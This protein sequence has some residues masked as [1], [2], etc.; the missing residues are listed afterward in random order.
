MRSQIPTLAALAVLAAMSATDVRAGEDFTID[1]QGVARHYLMHRPAS[2]APERPLVIF[3]HELRPAAWQ[4]H[5]QPD[6]DAL[7]DRE[8][9][10]VIYPEALEHRWNYTGQLSAPVKAD[11]QIADDV[12]FIRNLIDDL[13][14]RRLVDPRLVYAIGDSRGGLVTFELM[15]HLADR[16]AAAAP[17]ITGMTEG[18]RAACKPVRA[19]PIFA[20]DG[21]DDPVQPYDGWLFPTGRLLSVPETMEFW[22][23]QHSC[24]GQ[25]ATL[26][27]H[28]IEADPTKL[29]PV[30]MLLDRAADSLE[31]QPRSSRRRASSS[32]LRNPRRAKSKRPASPKTNTA[33]PG[34]SGTNSMTSRLVMKLEFIGS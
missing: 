27:P 6:F 14:A 30:G 17:L 29:L 23:E 8:D 18:Q 34:G 21:T 2:D 12:G 32:S 20:V 33:R 11:D 10:V 22:R 31:A 5:S 28:R 13:V 24:I 26:L 9:F 15:C 16:I 1:H 4:N 3:L 25:K 19:V 7:S